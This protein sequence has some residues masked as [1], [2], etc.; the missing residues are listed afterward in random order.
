MPSATR[1]IDRRSAG[2]GSKAARPARLSRSDGAARQAR[3][4]ARQ[5][6]LGRPPRARKAPH[7]AP[8]EPASPRCLK[9]W[10]RT[11][12]RVTGSQRASG[13]ADED[14][15]ELQG[16]RHRRL[17][18]ARREDTTSS[19]SRVVRS[20]AARAFRRARDALRGQLALSRGHCVGG[21]PR[22]SP[23]RT[24]A[25][26][27]PTTTRSRRAT[28]SRAGSAAARGRCGSGRAE[29]GGCRRQRRAPLG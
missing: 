26:A 7:Q 23:S 9:R 10:G 14:R 15:P 29:A 27:R 8:Q 4:P 16:A 24:C 18:P 5:A 2:A 21:Q 22:R 19:S 12:G 20:A 11:P 28:T 1:S 17:A 25:R 3:D 6:P 13:L